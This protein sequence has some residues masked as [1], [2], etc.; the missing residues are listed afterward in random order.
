MERL[1]YD[2][3]E[4][5]VGT[6]LAVLTEKGLIALH[7]PCAGGDEGDIPA[8]IRLPGKWRCEHSQEAAT[9]VMAQLA[10]YFR[11]DLRLF[12]IPLDL[13]GTP[14]QLLVWEELCRIPFGETITY[15]ELARRVG[16][17]GGARAVGMA[18]NRN[19]AGIVV[20]CHRVIGADGSL[21]GYGGGVEIKAILLRHEREC[22]GS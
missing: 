6:V 7:Y 9:P 13:R 4:S 14:F 2:F 12:S 10:A 19:R 1:F 18:N 20:P 16:R 8:L 5:P 11:G 3:A 15:G 17:P 22:S 21:V